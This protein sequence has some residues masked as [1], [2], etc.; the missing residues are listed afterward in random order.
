MRSKTRR[1]TFGAAFQRR[2]VNR[3]TPARRGSGSPTRRSTPTRMPVPSRGSGRAR[4]SKPASA[5]H[6]TISGPRSGSWAPRV[7]MTVAPGAQNPG[8]AL[9]VG[10]RD[11]AHDPDQEDQVCRDGAE[12]GVRHRGVDPAH[13]QLR[14]EVADPRP[15]HGAVVLQQLQERARG[16][17]PQLGAGLQHPEDVSALAGAGAEHPH[18]P[19]HAVVGGADGPLDVAQAHRQRGAGVV[20][21][22]VPGHVVAQSRAPSRAAVRADGDPGQWCWTR[23][24]WHGPA[25]RR[26]QIAE[27][28]SPRTR[29]P[30]GRARADTTRPSHF[31]RIPQLG[32]RRSAP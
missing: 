14:A 7:Q 15:G 17:V 27:D 5:N 4:C 31:V 19:G 11:I 18:R 24:V 20:V 30:G 32:P 3:R 8:E 1:L 25:R 22:L 26:P 29:R 6:R 2:K 9:D 10:R 23:A 13:L 28:A 12:V 16:P 21:G